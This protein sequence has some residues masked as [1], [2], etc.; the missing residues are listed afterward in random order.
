MLYYY[1]FATDKEL[2]KDTS[3]CTQQ[4]CIT[5]L[6]FVVINDEYNILPNRQ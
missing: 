3:C 2:Q 5:H 1:F 6:L 4:L